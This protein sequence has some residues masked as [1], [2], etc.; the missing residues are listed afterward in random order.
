MKSES[1]FPTAH[2]INDA[3]FEWPQAT[4]PDTEPLKPHFRHLFS[5]QV[6]IDAIYNQ[7]RLP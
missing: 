1:S 6:I 7:I 3:T 4:S 2:S 5:Y